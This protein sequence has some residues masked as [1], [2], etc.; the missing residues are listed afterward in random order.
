PVT[1]DR[2][3]E[4]L[5]KKPQHIVGENI[6]REA[7]QILQVVKG[8]RKTRTPRRSG[9]KTEDFDHSGDELLDHETPDAMSSECH[10]KAYNASR[11]SSSQRR[12]RE[13]TEL[14]VPRE[15]CGRNR[16]HSEERQEERKPAQ[17]RSHVRLLEG[18]SNEGRPLNR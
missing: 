18:R 14:Q 2:V 11:Y 15:D 7:I 5:R 8:D 6:Q 17:Y 4:A 3:I 13:S 16:A 9:P 10:T 12:K 1:N